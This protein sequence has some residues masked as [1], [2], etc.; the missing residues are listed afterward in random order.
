V[1][2]IIFIGSSLASLDGLIKAF[3]SYFPIK[4]LGNLNFF[5]GVEVSWS[6]TG[7]HLYQQWY[8]TNLLHRTNMQLAKPITSPMLA[9]T[10]LSKFDGSLLVGVYE[11]G[12]Y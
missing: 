5:V 4:D 3:S 9:S 10:S 12:G 1:D 2:D 8:I 6:T 11:W 7:L